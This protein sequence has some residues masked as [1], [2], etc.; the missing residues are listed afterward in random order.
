MF[1]FLLKILNVFPFCR[2]LKEAEK[3]EKIET[4]RREKEAKHQLFIEEKKRKQEEKQE[5]KLKKLHEIEMKRQQNAIMKEQVLSLRIPTLSKFSSK[6]NDCLN[7]LILNFTLTYL[8]LALDGVH[9]HASGAG[10]DIFYQA[11]MVCVLVFLS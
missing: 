8:Q 9:H 3:R 6:T 7:Q 11:A 4:A 5:E 1:L 10:G 2:I